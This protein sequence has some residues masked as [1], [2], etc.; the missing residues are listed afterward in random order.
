MQVISRIPGWSH[1]ALRWARVLTPVAVIIAFSGFAAGCGSK[2]AAVST[3]A[4]STITTPV[5]QPA[6]TIAAAKPA[7]IPTSAAPRA[8]AYVTAHGADLKRVRSLEASV[9]TAIS[10]VEN[11]PVM[12]PLQQ[13]TQQ[14]YATLGKVVPRL[15]GP[16]GHDPLGTTESE[17]YT[18]SKAIEKSMYTL[19]QYTA[20][21][22]P[23]TLNEYTTLYQN[24]ILGWNRA[25]QAIW[26]AAGVATPPKICTTC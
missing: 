5:K 8:K 9:Q 12:N 17:V 14:A 16:F 22:T 7:K 19:L 6:V 1:S 18:R 20:F 10:E 11:S 4:S 3:P 24:A 2:S 13:S 26:L 25:V 21:P 15:R 23:A